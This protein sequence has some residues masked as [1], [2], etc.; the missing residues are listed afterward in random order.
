MKK[1]QAS[2]D[3]GGDV[4]SPSVH[5]V[6]GLLKQFL[7]ELPDPL[8]TYCLYPSFVQAQNL[9]GPM[10]RSEALLLLCLELP[11]AHFQVTKF[12]MHLLYDVVHAPG[13]LM[14]APNL[15]AI[16]TPNVLRPEDEKHSS[17]TGERELANHAACV[18]I[19]EFL[20]EHHE[21]IGTAPLSVQ[22]R[23]LELESEDKARAEYLSLVQGQS[24]WWRNPFSRRQPRVNPMSSGSALVLLKSPGPSSSSGVS[25]GAVRSKDS[26]E[27]L[28]AGKPKRTQEVV[29]AVGKKKRPSH[30]GSESPEAP[31]S[32]APMEQG[33]DLPVAPVSG[34]DSFM[35]Y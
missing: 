10:Q 17:T 13:S 9:P 18:S 14:S 12:V 8:L 32:D 2:I 23:S 16:F 5:D 34:F 20:I 6:A 31:R 25:L 27:D 21:M 15:A 22:R 26:K 24:S 35:M 30:D 28:K 19:V 4:D 7:R 29:A 3:S 1:A 11:D 33:S